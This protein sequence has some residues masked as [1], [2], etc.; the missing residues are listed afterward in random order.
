MKKTILVVLVIW[1]SVLLAQ[2]S[3]APSG[4]SQDNSKSGKGQI[5]VQGCVGRLSGDYIL[6]RQ[7]PA[8]TYELQATGKIKF[9]HYLGQRVEVTGKKSASLSTSSDSMAPG[10]SPTS[11]MLTVTSIKKIAKEC[12]VRQVSGE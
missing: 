2:E 7:D 11:G 1:A 5:T 6:T 3:N 4:S 12:S 10:G 9:R 8:T